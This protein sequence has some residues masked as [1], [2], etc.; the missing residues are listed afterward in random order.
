VASAEGGL[1]RCI[2]ASTPNG[3]HCTG[4]HALQM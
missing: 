4:L 3:L 1:R 2:I